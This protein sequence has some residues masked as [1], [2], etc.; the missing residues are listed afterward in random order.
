MVESGVNPG[1]FEPSVSG[2]QR[3]NLIRSYG[4]LYSQSRVETLEYLDKLD[5]L[6]GADELKSKLL[7]SV[8]VVSG[9]RSIN[10]LSDRARM[11]ADAAPTARYVI[12]SLYI[13]I[14]TL[15]LAF[16]SLHATSSQMKDHVRRILQIP[17]GLSAHQHHANS[18]SIA[19]PP[20]PPPPP[21]VLSAAAARP[22]PSPPL[23]NSKRKD[24]NPAFEVEQAV[25][26]YLRQSV[27]TFDLTKNTE[28]SH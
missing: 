5:E 11:I 13:K 28:V 25:A 2:E 24:R 19:P 9:K 23:V 27:D 22:A 7:F 4:N 14:K 3:A 10:S 12:I 1:K 18:S 15:Q 17:P 16:R 20:P 6:R 26:S 8:I 21:C